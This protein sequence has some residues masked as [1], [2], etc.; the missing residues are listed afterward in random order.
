MNNG[1]YRRSKSITS[2]S[3]VVERIMKPRGKNQAFDKE[4]CRRASSRGH[5]ILRLQEVSPAQICR[6][7]DGRKRLNKKEAIMPWTAYALDVHLLKRSLLGEFSGENFSGSSGLLGTQLSRDHQ[8][9]RKFARSGATPSQDRALG[10][11]TCLGECAG[12][13]LAPGR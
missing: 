12:A 7:G 13:P 9:P 8:A 5:K 10:A 2:N 11:L 6:E 4:Q 3:I 1:E